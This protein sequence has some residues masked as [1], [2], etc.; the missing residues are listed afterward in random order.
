MRVSRSHRKPGYRAGLFVLE[1]NCTAELVGF[2]ARSA[3]AMRLT[4]CGKLAEVV[5][6][7]LGADHSTLAA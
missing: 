4:S 2:L 5:R 3:P 6:A 1:T 7:T